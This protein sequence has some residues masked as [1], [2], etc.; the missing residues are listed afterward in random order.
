MIPTT[1]GQLIERYQV[2]LIDA[3]GVLITHDG[4]LPGAGELIA[5]LSSANKPF[6][7]VTNDASRS[8]ERSAERYRGLGL[9]IAA[10]QIIT[11]GLLLRRHFADHGLIG[12]RCV[13]LGPDDSL[14]Y[15]RSAGGEIVDL[16]STEDAEAVIICDERGFDVMPSLDRVLS[17]LFRR[18]DDGQS[19]ALIVPNPDLIYPADTGRFGFTAGALAVMFEEALAQRYPDRDDLRFVRLGKPHRAIFEEA[20]RRAGTDDLVMIGDQLA[21][22]ILGAARYG[23]DSALVTT[24]LTRVGADGLPAAGYPADAQATY[25]LRSLRVE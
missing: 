24:G 12:A 18:A 20:R 16:D 13:V 22:D 21:T 8:V 23:I 10:E 15:V 11:S 14:E 7:I 17:M 6:F 4:V 19:T 5:H 1:A 3:Y 25:L 9:S 2:L